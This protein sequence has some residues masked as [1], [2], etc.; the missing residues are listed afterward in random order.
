[1]DTLLNILWYDYETNYKLHIKK[2]HLENMPSKTTVDCSKELLSK[3]G[4][5]DE[6]INENG[7]PF[8]SEDFQDFLSEFGFKHVT[9]SLHYAQSNE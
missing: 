4:L 8:S 2:K 5:I 6:M 3:E 9:S 1:M 7:L